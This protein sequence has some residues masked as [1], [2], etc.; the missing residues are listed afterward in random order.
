MTKLKQQCA[1]AIGLI[2]VVFVAGAASGAGSDR[3]LIIRLQG[4]ITVLQRQIRDLQET[5]DRNHATSSQVTA[6]MLE[7]TENSGKTISTLADR[8]NQ[9]DSLQHNN[10]TGVVKRLAQV[11]ENVSQSNGQLIE[12]NRTLREIRATLQRTAQPKPE[13]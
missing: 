11:E 10:L 1:V 5:I 12:M 7:N 13:N 8:L 4:E 3:D 2:L 6:R 9:T